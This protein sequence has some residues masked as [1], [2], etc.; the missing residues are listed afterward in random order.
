MNMG[1]E[2]P[3]DLNLI[4]LSNII[5]SE[6]SEHDKIRKQHSNIKNLINLNDD[7]LNDRFQ[8]FENSYYDLD[9]L[10]NFSKHSNGTC[11]VLNLTN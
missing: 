2:A 6:Q 5:A 1:M 11:G 3:R 9:Q 10:H 4:N 8:S 7:T